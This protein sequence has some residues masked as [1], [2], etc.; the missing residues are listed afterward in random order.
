MEIIV[1]RTSPKLPCDWSTVATYSSKTVLARLFEAN[2]SQKIQSPMRI[3]QRWCCQ[4]LNFFLKSKNLNTTK[5]IST[6]PWHTFLLATLC[7][8]VKA[9]EPWWVMPLLYLQ[10]ALIP[11]LGFQDTINPKHSMKSFK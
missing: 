6:V 5:G 1:E 8:Y 3:R 4:R 11:G 10:V 9:C 7:L 2:Y